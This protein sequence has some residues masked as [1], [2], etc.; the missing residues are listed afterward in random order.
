VRGEA[1]AVNDVIFAEATWHA[2]YEPQRAVRTERWKYIR[3]FDE[4]ERPVLP[5]TDDGPSKDYLLRHG[6]GERSVPHEQLYDLVLDPGEASNLAAEPAARDVL[7]ELRARLERWMEETDDPLLHGPLQPPS[8]V[9]VN[10]PD[11]LSSSEPTT[12]VP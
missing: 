11:G 6:W 12:V 8:G 9:E 4:R 2:A 5:N 7:A 10:D 3:R 1:A